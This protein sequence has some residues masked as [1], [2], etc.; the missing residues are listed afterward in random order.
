[1]NFLHRKNQK[2]LDLLIFSLYP[3]LA[4]VLSFLFNLNFAWSVFL[5]FGLPSIHLSFL[6]PKSIKKT[7]WFSL[8][9]AIPLALIVDHIAHLTSIWHVPTIF[10]FR[11]FGQVTVEDV[12]WGILLAYYTIMF[13][14]YFYDA[15]RDRKLLR[16]KMKI[17]L[18][19]I[20]IMFVV[21]LIVLYSAPN[22]LD[23]PFFYF[24]FG[25]ILFFLPVAVEF[26]RKPK[27][28]EK[29]LPT[30]V[31]FFY[32][33]F[34]YEVTALKL[35]WWTFPGNEVLGWVTFLGERF[36]FEE[37]FFWFVITAMTILSY[38]EFYDDDEK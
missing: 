3:V 17:C 19:I 8:L 38:Y 1:M 2:G 11:I 23:I 29:F 10:P 25:T 7:L 12:V 14:E 35:G 6:L 28:V 9:V 22:L 36:P 5:F 26:W 21:F 31:Y 34:V 4:S 37:L 27:L 30:A 32:V 18:S 16:P 33:S 13:Y 15:H 20:A 24:W